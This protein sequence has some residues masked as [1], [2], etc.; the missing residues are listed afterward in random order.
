MLQERDLQ[1]LTELVS[2]K[3]PIL[4]LYLNIDPQRRSADEHKLVLRQLLAQA[5]SQGAAASDVERIERF[6]NHEYNRQGRSL[7]CFSHQENDFWRVY[8]LLV[9]MSDY[10]YVGTRPYIKPLS[11]VLDE[12]DRFGVV[13]VDREGAR[14]FVYHLGALEDSAGTMGTEVKRHKQGGWGAQKLQRHED[15]E[16]KHNL[17]DAA[18]WADNYLREHKVNRVVLAG[19]D[20]NVA[21]FRELLSRPLQ[22]K[23]VG[24]VSLDMNASPAEAWER[25]YEVARE[26]QRRTEA[27]LLDQ[28]VTLAHKGGAGVVGLSDTLAALQ[29]GR[30]YHLMV[31]HGL[32][33]PGRQCANCEAVVIEELERCPYCENVLAPVSDAVDL[34]VHRAV[35]SGIKVSVMEPGPLMEQAGGVAAVVRY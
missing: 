9:P 26:A 16:A 4:S 14:A 25:S 20:G 12:Y 23:V 24:Q 13:S 1:E 30:V 31:Q 10:V 7:A 32:H 35:E 3:S 34:A 33:V 27:A 28:V 5:A 11:D 18:D 21:M 15:G 17:K 22:D 29:Q 6:F 8:T 2:A 19:S